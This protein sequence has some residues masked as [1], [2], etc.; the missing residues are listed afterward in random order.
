MSIT[1]GF[2]DSLIQDISSGGT[3]SGDVTVSGDMTVSGDVSFQVDQIIE[4]QF[5][6]DGTSTEAVLVRKDSDGG[7]VFV[8]DTTNETVE[9]TQH[10]GT[11]KGLML[12]AVLVT[13]TA[14]ELNLLDGCTSSTAELNILDGVSATAAE[15]NILDG[16]SSTAAELNLIDGSSAGTIVNSKAVIYGSSGEVNATTLKI[17]GTA[18]TSTAAELNIMDGD[19]SA[20]STTLADADRVVVNDN[21]TMKQVALTDL[22]VYMETSL[23]TLSNVT[24]TGALNA[25]S[26]TSGFGAIDIGSSA[27]STTGSV[28]LGATTFGDNDITNVG[29][30]NVDSVSSDDGS[31][32]DLVLDD[33]KSAA[34]EIKESSNAYMTFVTTNSGEKIQVDKALD[35]NAVSDFGTNAMTNVNIDSG[36]I[37]GSI[38]GGASAAAGSFTTITASTSLDVTGSA[39]IILENDETI[40]NSTN[41]TVA[42][43]GIV[44][45]GTGSAAGVY[46]SSGDYDVTLQTGN[47]TTGTITITDGANGNIAITPNGSGEVDITK[48]D[49]A[50]GEI[51]GTPIGANSAS[52]AAFT[53]A[54][55]SG[56]VNFDSGTFYVDASESRVG[57]GTGDNVDNLFSVQS[58]DL[59]TGWLRA[60][61]NR[62]ETI[63]ISAD[64][65]SVDI[66]SNNAG[67]WGSMVQLK[68]VNSTTF[69][70]NW[71]I[72]RQSGASGD[73]GLYFR[74]GTSSFVDGSGSSSV[75]ALAFSSAGAATFAGNVGVGGNLTVTGTSTFNGGT[76]T[77]GDA[78][79]DTIAF[80]GTIT[81]NLVF[82]G[83]S[84]DAHELTLSPGDPTG[85]VT[86]TLPVATDTLVGKATTDTLTNKTLTSPKIGTSVLDTNGNELF[87]LTATGSAVNEFTVANAATGGAPTISA[88]GGDS[89]IDITITPKGTGEVNIAAGN[90]NY[91]GTAITATG[92]ELNLIDG[93]TARGTTAVADG[94]GVLINDDGTMRMTTVQ[95]LATYMESE[96]DTF[97]NLE[98]TTELQT[99][100]IA[101]T[102]GDDAITIADGGGITAA[103][104]IT[105][106]AAANTL[107]ATSF[108]DAAITN[109]G[110][111]ALD[112]ISA[113]DTDINIAVTDN[114]AT[115]LTIK[116]GSDAY[117]IVDTANSSES[118]S[119][120]T[121]IS[122][123]VVT[124]GHA[125]SETT[126]AD[127]LSVTGNVTI[128]G[129]LL[130]TGDSSE[131]KADDLV[132]DNAT[133][134][135]GLTNGA[136]PSADSGFDIG[137]KPHWHTGSGAK[138]AFLGVDVSTSA[139]APK[140]TY[141][142][143]ASFSSNVVTGTAGIIVADL[144]G[145]VTTAAQTS[146]TSLGTLT[147]LTV[148]DVAINGKVVTMT[149]STDDT[150][151]FTVGT[152]G[153]L[154]IV[155]TDTAAAAGNITI[156]ADGTFEADGTTITLDS[157]G[158]IEFNADGAD[159][160]FKDGSATTLTVTNSSNDAVVTVGTQDKD[161]I[162]KG[163]DGGV[164]ITALT[165]D[166][167]G[168]GAATF[169]S[170]VTCTGLDVGDGHLTNVGNIACDAIAEESGA[171][172]LI[173]SFGGATTTNIIDLS[174]S[175]ANALNIKE[176]N[177]GS[178]LM[179]DTT[180][181]KMIFGQ[182]LDINAVSDFGNNAMTLVNIDSGAIDGTPIGANSAST[183]AFTTL[184]S[185]G[186]AGTSNTVLGVSA[187]ASLHSGSAY[188]VFIGDTVADATMTAT[189][190]YNVGVGYG[191]LTDLT[192]GAYNICIGGVAGEN[193]QDG[194][195]NV[196]IGT[197]CGDGLISETDN[198][199]IGHD[200]LSHANP[201]A[202]KVVAIGSGSLGGDLTSAA[203]GTIAI[204]YQAG[205]AIT[206]G[207]GNTAV[208]FQTLDACSTGDANTAVGYKA[209]ST[210]QTADAGSNTAMGY[211]V[212]FSLSSGTDN[213]Y[214]GRDAGYHNA[215]GSNNTYVGR[216]SGQGASGENNSWNTGVG[217]DALL[218]I[219]DGSYNTI[220]GGNVGIALTDGAENTMLGQNCGTGTTS[221]T[222]MVIVGRN[223]GRGVIT[224]A[225]TGTVLVGYNAGA[226]LTNGARNLAIGY[227]SADSLTTSA[228]NLAIG[229]GALGSATTNT[230]QNIAI[231]NYALDG[232]TAGETVTDNTA[233]GYGAGTAL[234]TGDSNTLIGMQA[235]DVITTGGTNTIIGKDADPS[236]NSAT[237]QTVIGSDT[238]GQADN[239]V[240]LGNASVNHVYMAQDSHAKVHCGEIVATS[241]EDSYAA[242]ISGTAGAASVVFINK[243]S[244]GTYITWGTGGVA[245]GTISE[246][247]GTVSYGAFTAHHDA[248]LPSS[249]ND[250]GYPYGTLVE[251]TEI[252][253]TQEDGVDSERG[254]VYKVQK[255]SSAYAKNVLGSYS[256]KYP[257]PD[258]PN[259][260]RIYVLGDGH[261]LC[262]GE[263]GNISV[264]DGI[265]TS[266]T[267]GEG[268]KADKMAMIIGIAQE[269]VSFSGSESKLVAVQYGLQQ[270]TPW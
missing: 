54:T 200:A 176:D 175:K 119:L 58:T 93:G 88:T 249:D 112:S 212:G 132:V 68:E 163:D 63:S 236:A 91:A 102:D 248:E 228:D 254:I 28:T 241:D 225:A 77:L 221:G 156:T 129:N 79:G 154:S 207:A 131:V 87:K 150:A 72:V 76:I 100:L 261:I 80:G 262:N 18:I 118:V 186:G 187:G 253:Y 66:V 264:G 227:Q 13:S 128:S 201:Q 60:S 161:F 81:G 2:S 92:A 214:M 8:V 167:S 133:I 139:S 90:L 11:N 30:I 15:L 184:K 21:G 266:S 239:S 216:S 166:M 168:A 78:A 44:A 140:L 194:S 256:D 127:N 20:T 267:D 94:D 33:N 75:D 3:I 42:I 209:L 113:D 34:L 46:Q 19:T 149:G 1:H 244:S 57:I 108:N 242:E 134:A 191:A 16:V 206:S 246:S 62:D 223:A 263:K 22:E 259:L 40:T 155:T 7:D 10:N 177:A 104:G 152:N 24:T 99:A 105:S 250:D 109:V 35:I 195:Q 48:V 170:T 226:A 52:T 205:A 50:G 27:L 5:I 230:T 110:D 70:D 95:T 189:A 114:S 9:I 26:I 12:G 196:L 82:E 238:T 255:S 192:T 43:N 103:A 148:D 74:Y 257:T 86:V 178:F 173:I 143:D 215:T 146:I 39:G 157:A 6:V 235:G 234:T 162:V 49:I 190:D 210:T 130:I 98:V 268:M 125:T 237:N 138:T 89:N 151:V 38:I 83:S 73:S 56:D 116:Q 126:V 203:D 179:F 213:V 144:E 182:A 229:Y 172:G 224:A 53:T 160:A 17:A 111:I 61:G 96:I 164:A 69:V 65:S 185:S 124:I 51:D 202:D 29:D 71:A 37:D 14:A 101:Y 25:G 145:T 23:D 193:I 247:G 136:A 59:G 171:N 55:A 265:C 169:N 115:A 258:Y 122:G 135:M 121:G 204:G 142:P 97:A 218:A 198:V 4:G 252:D 153:T 232:I 233:V 159:V 31:G 260:H 270:F 67:T 106:T 47:S 158:D 84:A 117:L 85:D 45:A 165:L 222:N 32:F 181:E 199:A 251:T 107:G 188:N 41:G 245:K 208:G 180:N 137:L 217:K 240:T 147:A 183:G 174:D 120:G 219:E 243:A 231:G 197:S 123:T 269:D 211:T 141:I 36:A 220:V 64:D